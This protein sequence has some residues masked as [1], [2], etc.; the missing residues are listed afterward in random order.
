MIVAAG[1]SQ[2][3]TCTLEAYTPQKDTAIWQQKLSSCS[4]P[5]SA[6]YTTRGSVVVEFN[7]G[8]SD[9]IGVI[10]G[11]GKLLWRT[12][13]S[14][15]TISASG[16]DGHG[17]VVTLTDLGAGV[18]LQIFSSDT[19]KLKYSFSDFG[20]YYVSPNAS[21]VGRGNRLYC[22]LNSNKPTSSTL[23]ALELP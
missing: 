3:Q 15:P 5:D 8:E 2:E 4:Q 22:I 1:G 17:D 11:K 21:I 18:Q 9:E 14:L 16:V 7:N 6:Y 13:N 10:D 23:F 12:T 19:G 20:A